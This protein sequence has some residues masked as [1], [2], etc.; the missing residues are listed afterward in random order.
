MQKGHSGATASSTDR[1]FPDQSIS[2]IGIDWP[3]TRRDF[4]VLSAGL[5][6]KKRLTKTVPH[7]SATI[8]SATLA[9]IST[10]LARFF[11][12]ILF[13]FLFFI[14]PVKAG[15]AH[16]RFSPLNDEIKS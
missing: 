1:S 16:S 8:I 14:R 13:P 3:M 15:A 11:A 12:A 6:K 2:G 5:V 10:L 4:I 9:A 7:I